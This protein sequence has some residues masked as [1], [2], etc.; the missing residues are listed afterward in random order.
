MV[1]TGSLSA[2]GATS[3]TY[4]T[5]WRPNT[6]AGESYLLRT[7][8]RASSSWPLDIADVGR[9]SAVPRSGMAP[10]PDQKIVPSTATPLR[11][12]WALSSWKRYGTSRYPL[13][14]RQH[15]RPA[16]VGVQAADGVGHDGSGACPHRRE[17]AHVGVDDDVPARPRTQALGGQE[18]QRGERGPV[19]VLI[20][21]LGQAHRDVPD[22]VL[23][24]EHRLQHGQQAR[25]APLPIM[26]RHASPARHRGPQRN[27]A[28]GQAVGDRAAL[29]RVDAARDER[30][31]DFL[32][33]RTCPGPARIE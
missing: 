2:D 4:L 17:Q 5:W 32:R 1:T 18:P 20:G 27:P 31:H 16:E 23:P 8:D 3:P 22:P 13:L 14:E 15:H 33:A 11:A 10:T 26:Q 6:A 30:G 19:L 7:M 12:R 25:R 29:R 28:V 21:L 9:I 24:E